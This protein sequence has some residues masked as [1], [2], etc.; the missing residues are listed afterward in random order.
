VL[1]CLIEEFWVF[2][3]GVVLALAYYVGLVTEIEIEPKFIIM[4]CELFN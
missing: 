3:R 2:T 1:D 4:G